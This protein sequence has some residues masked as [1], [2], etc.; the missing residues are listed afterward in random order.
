MQFKFCADFFLKVS[1]WM[2][3]DFNLFLHK[4]QKSQDKKNRSQSKAIL[5]FDQACKN[6]TK[7]KTTKKRTCDLKICNLEKFSCFSQIKWKIRKKKK[8]KNC[9]KKKPNQSPK[10]KWKS[11]CNQFWKIFFLMIASHKDE[12]GSSHDFQFIWIQKFNEL[13]RKNSTWTRPTNPSEGPKRQNSNQIFKYS[14]E[15]KYS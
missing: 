10:T 3:K 13:A 11:F 12:C 1:Y 15:F 5:N 4:R 9:P 14:L 8:T 2:L 6:R 7:L